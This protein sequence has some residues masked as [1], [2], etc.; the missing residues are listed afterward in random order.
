MTRQTFGNR[1]RPARFCIAFALLALVFVSGTIG[2]RIIQPYWS[3][4]RNGG[5]PGQIGRYTI[6]GGGAL[7]IRSDNFR[8]VIPAGA[9]ADGTT[10]NVSMVYE[11]PIL[12]GTTQTTGS[13]VLP[14]DGFVKL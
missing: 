7:D 5:I 14:P 1:S 12:F 13:R 11:P 9:A 3:E 6:A 4:N 8:L 10:L 2:C